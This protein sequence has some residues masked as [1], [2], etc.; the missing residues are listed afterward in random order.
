M[1][2][3]P[4]EMSSNGQQFDPGE[5]LGETEKFVMWEDPSNKYFCSMRAIGSSSPHKQRAVHPRVESTDNKLF[6]AAAIWA[7][8]RKL[9]R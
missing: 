2:E 8:A 7:A 6:Q 9:G 4:G 5:N 1:W 3:D